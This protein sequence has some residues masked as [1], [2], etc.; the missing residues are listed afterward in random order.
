MDK[1]N[2]RVCLA[3]FTYGMAVLLDEKHIIPAELTNLPVAKAAQIFGEGW[4][5][6]ALKCYAVVIAEG[7]VP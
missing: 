7:V 3:C 6:Y 4:D 1:P 2:A 5:E